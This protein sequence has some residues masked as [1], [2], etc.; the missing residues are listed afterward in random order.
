MDK[1]AAEGITVYRT[2]EQG[3]L[4]ATS[5]GSVITWNTGSGASADTGILSDESAS[6]EKQSPTAIHMC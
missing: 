5:D 3:T 6:E 1:L 2:D 4:T